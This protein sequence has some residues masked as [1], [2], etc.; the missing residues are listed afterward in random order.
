MISVE[1]ALQQVLTKI[2]PL[3]RERVSLI[4]SQG[5]VLAENISAQRDIPP[6]D[7]SAMD[8]YALRWPDIQGVSGD[9]PAILKVLADLPAGRIYKGVVGPGEAIRIMTGAPIPKGADTVVPV[10][11][12]EKLGEKVRIRVTLGR[13]SNLRLAGEDVKA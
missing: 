1:E 3:G 9:Q 5:R 13:G 12:T 2:R 7:N 4:Q 10:E 6:W 11:D 8:G